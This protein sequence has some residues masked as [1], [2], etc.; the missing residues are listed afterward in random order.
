MKKPQNTHLIM[1]EKIYIFVEKL[2]K[3]ALIVIHL[4]MDVNRWSGLIE[5]N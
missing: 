4:N 2:A 5:K 3:I 1:M